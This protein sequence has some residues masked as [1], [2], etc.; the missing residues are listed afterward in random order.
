LAYIVISPIGS[1][2]REEIM[3]SI[4][5]VSLWGR[6][7]L[8]QGAY[9]LAA[10]LLFSGPIIALVCLFKKN[11]PPFLKRMS[12][13]ALIGMILF[14]SPI[15]GIAAEN[16]IGILLWPLSLLSWLYIVFGKKVGKTG[17]PEVL[18]CPKKVN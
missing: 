15:L 11:I 12:K 4:D 13:I 14:T 6:T 3:G 2:L 16:K 17:G 10:L 5:I 1:Q 18:H 9:D 8:D 7:W